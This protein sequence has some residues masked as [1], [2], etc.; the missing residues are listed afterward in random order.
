MVNKE[1]KVSWVLVLVMSILFG[2]LGVDRFILGKVWTGLL[3]MV[4]GVITVFGI[5]G[6]WI[7]WLVDI[8]LIATKYPFENVKWID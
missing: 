3:K 4:I 6:G 1:K 5:F 2:G 8:I 7:W